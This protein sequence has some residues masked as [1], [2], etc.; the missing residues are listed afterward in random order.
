MHAKYQ[1]LF[2]IAWICKSCCPPEC[3]VFG[4]RLRRYGQSKLANLLYA[5]AI[6]D[7]Y[8]SITAVSVH[9]GVGYTGLHRTSNLIER[10]MVWI[11]TFR[12]KVPTYKLAWNGLW[13]ATA[14]KGSGPGQVEGGL[15][16]SPVGLRSPSLGMT[17]SKELEDELWKWTQMELKGWKARAD[18][19]LQ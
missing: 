4:G 1:P 16:Y 13:A 19:K 12:N 10:F 3:H 9:P 6:D 18:K 8:T 11:T 5:R 7:R 15:C 14:P 2:P 17:G